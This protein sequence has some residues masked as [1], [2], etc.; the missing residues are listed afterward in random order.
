MTQLFDTIAYS[1]NRSMVE[2]VSQKKVNKLAGSDASLPASVNH[3]TGLNRD[4]PGRRLFH[5]G[6][7]EPQH[8]IAELGIDIFLSDDLG[9]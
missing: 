8:A 9:E 6:Q 5:F 3:L 2:T 1:Q 4:T 7:G